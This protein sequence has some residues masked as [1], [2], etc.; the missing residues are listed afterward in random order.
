M[1]LAGLL[2]QAP[3]RESVLAQFERLRR[4]N[5]DA[6][7]TMAIENYLEMRATVLAPDFTARR[8]LALD[9]E[10]RFPSASFRAMRW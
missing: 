6:I 3:D 10:R 9:L 5:T 1:L 7:A 2:R 8:Q 4:P